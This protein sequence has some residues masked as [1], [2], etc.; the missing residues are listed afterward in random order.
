MKPPSQK[1]RKEKAVY[2]LLQRIQNGVNSLTFRELTDDLMPSSATGH[3]VC[4]ECLFKK[5]QSVHIDEKPCDHGGIMCLAKISLV[6]TAD[7]RDSAIWR[8]KD[9]MEKR[10][11]LKKSSLLIERAV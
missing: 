6:L 2:K 1:T 10:E 5:C 7:K 3:Q 11:R 8:R 4:S 9:K